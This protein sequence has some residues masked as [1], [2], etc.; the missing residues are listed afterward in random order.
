MRYLLVLVAVAALA[1]VP[2]AHGATAC[3]GATQGKVQLSKIRAS[4]LSCTTATKVAKSWAKLAQKGHC[5][6]PNV[7][8]TA[9]CTVSGYRCTVKAQPGVAGPKELPTCRRGVRKATWTG[10]FS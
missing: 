7:R 5:V 2:A 10:L 6:P 9:K 3:P 1:A 8:S 4:S